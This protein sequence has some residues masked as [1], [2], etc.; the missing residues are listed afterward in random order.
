MNR[1][2]LRTAVEEKPRDVDTFDKCVC[3]FLLVPHGLLAL[4][5]SEPLLKLVFEKQMKS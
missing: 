1:S 5:D 3:W 2:A 4:D